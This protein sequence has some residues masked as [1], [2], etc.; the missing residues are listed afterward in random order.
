MDTDNHI[1]KR[2][3][4]NAIKQTLLTHS[5]ISFLIGLA[6]LASFIYFD[7][8]FH[9]YITCLY[10]FINITLVANLRRKIVFELD[11]FELRCSTLKKK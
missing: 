5:L 2:S 6:F 1:E 3:T 11:S 10:F 9:S 4:V 7:G 8:S